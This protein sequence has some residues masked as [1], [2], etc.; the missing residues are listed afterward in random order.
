MKE[1]RI[2]QLFKEKVPQSEKVPPEEV[3]ENISAQLT[4]RRKNKPMVLPFW[5]KLAGVAAA[6]ILI[7][8]IFQRLNSP[9]I[10]SPAV[11]DKPFKKD[12]ELK[13]GCKINSRSNNPSTSVSSNDINSFKKAAPE[14]QKGREKSKSSMIKDYRKVEPIGATFKTGKIIQGDFLLSTNTD[15][16][17]LV[18]QKQTLKLITKE[19]DGYGEEEK[20]EYAFKEKITIAPTVA[21]VY[22]GKM[23]TGHTLDDRFSENSNP[24][25]INLVYGI[26]L[27]YH[28]SDKLKL[29]SGVNNI[30]FSSTTQ[31]VDNASA[32]NSSAINPNAAATISIPEGMGTLTQQLSFLEIPLELEYT[33]LEKKVGLNLIFGTSTYFLHENA[34]E[35]ESALVTADLGPANN[36]KNTSFSANLGLGLTYTFSPKFQI[37]LD[38]IIKYQINTYENV[39]DLKPYFFGIY[40]GIRVK[41]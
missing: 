35:L 40:S 2:D 26:S 1:N 19:N 14:D 24:E 6:L 22:F 27:A 23:G 36:I 25:E 7:L 5:Y 20:E 37:N 10:N 39:S 21:A 18:R 4:S 29:R 38:P 41:L 34:V 33:L 31:D 28:F 15:F 11:T 32:I 3:W 17:Y 8:A 30:T 9:S 12:G 13:D 16:P